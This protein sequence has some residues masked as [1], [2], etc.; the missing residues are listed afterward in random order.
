M[1]GMV[2]AELGQWYMENH[3]S[4]AQGG[5]HVTAMINRHAGEALIE[6]RKAELEAREAAARKTWG[7]DGGSPMVAGLEED[8][9]IEPGM[10]WVRQ[11]RTI[12][13]LCHMCKGRAAASRASS[14]ARTFVRTTLV[15]QCSKPC[16][17]LASW[18][19]SRRA[20][21]HPGHARTCLSNSEY[22]AAGKWCLT[23]RS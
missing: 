15:L 10:E 16:F 12:K 5:S 1:K 22:A 20:V 14:G 6:Q 11:A 17:F 23:R 4:G 21:K 9:G 18:S 19:S 2:K 13:T 8:A 7:K 3:G